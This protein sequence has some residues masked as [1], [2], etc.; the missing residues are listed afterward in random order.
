MMGTITINNNDYC[1][2]LLIFFH[3][4]ILT[5]FSWGCPLNV[6]LLLYYVDDIMLTTNSNGLH[7]LWTQHFVEIPVLA[8]L[9]ASFPKYSMPKSYPIT[10]TCSA[11]IHA[12]HPYIQSPCSPLIPVKQLQRALNTEASC[13]HCVLHQCKCHVHYIPSDLVQHQH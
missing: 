6:H 12:S 13:K 5:H 1:L 4:V 8:L 10:L 2:S 9:P 3:I 11:A 7:G